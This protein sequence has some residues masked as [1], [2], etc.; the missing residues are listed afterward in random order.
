MRPLLIAGI[1]AL[2]PG[3]AV[4]QETRPDWDQKK[5]AEKVKGLDLPA[6]VLTPEPLTS[7]S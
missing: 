6:A 1:L 7:N 3:L 4:A 5:A 2:A